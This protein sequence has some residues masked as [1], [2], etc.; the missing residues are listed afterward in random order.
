[1]FADQ[2]RRDGIGYVSVYQAICPRGQCR[3]TD[4]DG[5]PLAFDY[6]HLTASGSVIVAEQIRRSGAL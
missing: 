3:M 4:Q 1:L 6:G 2:L 5:L